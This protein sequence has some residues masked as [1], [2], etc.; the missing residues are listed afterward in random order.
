MECGMEDC[1]SYE[2]V[3]YAWKPLRSV[4]EVGALRGKEERDKKQLREILSKD[5]DT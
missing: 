2:E 1:V 3:G 4:G 5:L